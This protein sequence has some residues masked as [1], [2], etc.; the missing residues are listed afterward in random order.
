MICL[1]KPL[2]DLVI[3]EL[4]HEWHNV[5]YPSMFVQDPNDI[6]QVRKPGLLK[7]EAHVKNGSMVCLRIVTMNGYCIY[8]YIRNSYIGKNPLFHRLSINSLASLALINS[9]FK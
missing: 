4:R 1:T 8:V 9:L 6:H 5:I 3:P 7:I 2:N